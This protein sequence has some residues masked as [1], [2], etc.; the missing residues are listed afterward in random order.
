MRNRRYALYLKSLDKYPNPP[1]ISLT[2][3]RP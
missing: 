2:D 3:F 1:A